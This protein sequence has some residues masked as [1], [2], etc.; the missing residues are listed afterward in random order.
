MRAAA[1]SLIAIVVGRGVFS[2]IGAQARAARRELAERGAPPAFVDPVAAQV[3]ATRSL[4]LPEGPVIDKA[5]EGWAKHV[6]VQRVVMAL[7]QMRV[8]LEAARGALGEAGRS[9]PPS[10]LVVGAAEA[11]AEGIDP[12]DVGRIATEA[13]NPEAGAAGLM[14]AA[15]LRAQG[16]DR[17]AAVQAVR[18]GLHRGLGPAQLYELPSAVADLTGRGI[19][20]TDVA[21]RI[22]EGGGLPL[23][24]TAGS[25][26]QGGGR[27][28][29]VPPGA[30]GQQGQG[31]SKRRK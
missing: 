22:M 28:G 7:E 24:P 18:D 1:W 19:A 10:A 9:N 16:L 27:P 31:T 26:G 4:G 15:S 2:P 17:P 30:G 3:E 25:P 21:R 14:V 6:Q 23:P 13:P 5:L 20:M 12:A 8:R 11:L 29:S